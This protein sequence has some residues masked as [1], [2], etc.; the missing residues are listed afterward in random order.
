MNKRM[1][2]VDLKHGFDN[3][4]KLIKQSYNEWKE[5]NDK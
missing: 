4:K 1:G 5:G 3:I 2:E